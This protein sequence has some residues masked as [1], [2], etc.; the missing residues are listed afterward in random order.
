M[1]DQDL[2]GQYAGFVSR[3]IAWLI[4]RGIIIAILGIAGWLVTYLGKI[5]GLDITQCPTTA[6]WTGYL[7]FTILAGLA[8]FTLTFAPLYFMFFWTLAGMTPGKALLGVR[9]V[10]LDG[11]PMTFR[12]SFRRYFGY[13]VSFLG[14]GMGYLW[15]L[16]DNRRQGWHD[17][18][19]GTCVVYSWSA[20]QNDL[21]I[22]RMTNWLFKSEKKIDKYSTKLAGKSIYAAGSDRES[23]AA[24]EPVSDAGGN[25][26]IITEDAHEPAQNKTAS[27]GHETTPTQE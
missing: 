22:D 3:L 10:R 13:V 17:K 19:A 14:F 26:D 24:A 21:L 4:D 8:L 20:R 27:S 16:I 11:H 7:C 9:I 15:I 1:V 2:Q 18:I 23:T 5:V 25:D 6:G 12:I